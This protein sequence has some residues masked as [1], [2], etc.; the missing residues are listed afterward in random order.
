MW[1]SWRD[2][3]LQQG[4]AR[5]LL[6]LTGCCQN[7][8]F[9]CQQQI[10][11]RNPHLAKCRH[12][13]CYPAVSR[14]CYWNNSSCWE[15]LRLL[16]GIWLFLWWSWQWSWIKWNTCW[17][18]VWGSRVVILFIFKRTTSPKCRMSLNAVCCCRWLLPWGFV[19][20]LKKH[21]F[22]NS[23]FEL[24]KGTCVPVPFMSNSRRKKPQELAWE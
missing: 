7:G 3:N 11:F 13:L 5:T 17:R 23:S 24:Q 21:L 2:G 10:C 8:D 18:R 14:L 6:T 12:R 22:D 19:E 15:I 9:L 20:I 1:Q 4:R 16:S